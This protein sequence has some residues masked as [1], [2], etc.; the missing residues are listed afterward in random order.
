MEHPARFELSAAIDA[1]R[2]ELLAQPGFSP[3]DRRELES[4]LCDAMDESRG[5]GMDDE[6]AFA[7]ARDRLGSIPQIAGEFAKVDPARVWSGRAFWMAVAVLFSKAWAMSVTIFLGPLLKHQP[8]PYLSLAFYAPVLGI[9]IMLSRG[10]IAPWASWVSRVVNSR[11][12]FAIV[13]AAV[14]LPLHWADVASVFRGDPLYWIAAQWFSMSFRDIFLIA[15]AAWFMPAQYRKAPAYREAAAPATDWQK[16]AWRERVFWMTLALLV[17]MIWSNFGVMSANAINR[18]IGQLVPWYS[19]YRDQAEYSLSCLAFINIL[20]SLFAYLPPL[21]LA[22]LLARGRAGGLASWLGRAF[23]SRTRFILAAIVVMCL[24]RAWYLASYEHEYT[25]V[26]W[27]ILLWNS[28]F[29]ALAA[30]LMPPQ[31]RKSSESA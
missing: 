25:L 2:G 19:Q 18:S 6:R 31:S 12:R 15:L 14:I 22:I 9:A 8:L 10:R 23:H 7:L 3:D 27:R 4:H 26:K 21:F 20:Y 17:E 29:V 24:L 30:W 28:A 11:A 13:A 5:S 16:A 1:W